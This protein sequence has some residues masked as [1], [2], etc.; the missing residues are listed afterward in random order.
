W[1]NDTGGSVA[2][3][4]SFFEAQV[5]YDIPVGATFTGDHNVYCSG[6]ATKPDGRFYHGVQYA[7]LPSNFPAWQAATGQ[8]DNSQATGSALFTGTPTT[9]DFRI[10]IDGVGA[11]QHWNYNLRELVAGPPERWP[12]PPS[13]YDDALAY[14]MDPEAW[15]FYG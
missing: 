1:I 8:D 7:N 14:I 13:T 5:I 15:D 6:V 3:N 10:S 2:V 12:V 11:T 4:D 9:G